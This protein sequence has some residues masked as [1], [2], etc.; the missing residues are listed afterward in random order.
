[1]AT[2]IADRYRLKKKDMG[3]GNMASILLCEDTD[4]ENDEADRSVII[5]M[6]NKSNI[7]DEDLQKQVFNREV[8]SLDKL[9]HKNIVRILDRGFDKGFQAYFIVLEYIQGQNFKDAFEDICRYEYAQKLELMEQVVEGIEYLHKK[10]IVHRDLK[11][12][13][14]MIDK[15]GTVKIIDF[16]ISRLQDTFYGDYTLAA[17]A[18]K[19]Y[20][21]PEQMS[22]KTITYQ[23]DIYSLG[24]I[25]YEIF[26]CSIDMEQK[27]DII[28]GLCRG[29]ESIHNYDTPL[30]HRNINPEAFY[31]FNIRGKYKPLL[32]KFDC[33]KDTAN[34][35]F[36]VFQNVEKKIHNQNSNQFFAPEV[37]EANMGIGVDWKKADIYSLAKT[38]LF[39]ISGAV[40]DDSTYLDKIDDLDDELKIVLMEMLDEKPENRPELSELIKLL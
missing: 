21:S 11:P 30:Y 34:A 25:F 40:I 22:G 35:A 17:F 38:I 31:I 6:F 9:N 10:N 33:T 4:I 3:K 14:L 12:S 16:G 36:T 8:E 37:I 29:I 15:E 7:G 32:A 39:I 18:T 13:N 27:M 19:N 20:S 23:S 2:Y 1:M 28:A 5:K 24:L 26:T